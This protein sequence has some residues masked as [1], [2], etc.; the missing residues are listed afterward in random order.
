M[1][2]NDPASPE[3]TPFDPR[4]YRTLNEKDGFATASWYLVATGVIALILAA[5]CLVLDRTGN[6]EIFTRK[7][8]VLN[9]RVVGRGLLF[10]GILCYAGGRAIS[11]WRRFSRRGRD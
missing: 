3:Q 8:F 2:E 9:P 4:A 1:H 5:I 10:F 7:D 6:L 11:Y